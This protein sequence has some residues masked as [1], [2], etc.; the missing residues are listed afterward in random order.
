MTAKAYNNRCIQLWL[1]SVLKRAAAAN[2][3][4]ERFGHASVMMILSCVWCTCTK[5]FAVPSFALG[6]KKCHDEDSFFQV[7]ALCRGVPPVPVT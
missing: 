6:A 2:P 3:H 5:K 1:E 4:N 7:H